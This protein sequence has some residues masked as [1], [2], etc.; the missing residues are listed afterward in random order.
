MNDFVPKKSRPFR[1][2]VI[3]LFFVVIAVAFS[4]VVKVGVRRAKL[5]WDD[6]VAAI[7]DSGEPLT[8]SDL[9][10]HFTYNSEN[11]TVADLLNA[12]LGDLEKVNDATVSEDFDRHV[13][14]IGANSPSIDFDKGILRYA[15][16]AS[17]AFVAKHAELLHSLR[18]STEMEP[19]RFFAFDSE[20]GFPDDQPTKQFRTAAK[21]LRLE[22]TLA[23]IDR[24]TDRA[25]QDVGAIFQLSA[26]AEN[27][28]SIIGRLIQIVTTGSAVYLINDSLRAGEIDAESLAQLQKKLEIRERDNMRW[29]LLGE[30]AYFVRMCELLLSGKVPSDKSSVTTTNRY[31]KIMPIRWFVRINQIRGV[32]MFSRM[33]AASDK[34]RDLIDA[35]LEIEEEVKGLSNRFWLAKTLMAPLSK[36]AVL[37][38]R[39]LS[40]IRCA[41]A[42]IAAEQFRLSHGQLPTTMNQLIPNYLPDRPIDPMDD[43]PIRLITSDE[44]L[45]IYSIGEDRKDDGGSVIA[46]EGE[47]KSRDWGYR[48]FKPELRGV[49]IS[50]EQ[51][52]NA[53]DE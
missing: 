42:M 40:E 39:L 17:R 7:R 27:T 32:E 30:R 18:K 51:P 23:L 20:N 14:I 29:A 24:D 28:P 49:K 26:S 25:L 22:A 8:F 35:T 13:L 15:I 46:I 36:T 3:P 53:D 10:T 43:Q 33:I 50:D 38:A 34:P 2:L 11:K 21:L 5:H 45:V 1:W 44:G 31:L 6:K 37:H 48:L 47:K 52:P 16:E 41:R 4:L 19:G 12:A 9:S